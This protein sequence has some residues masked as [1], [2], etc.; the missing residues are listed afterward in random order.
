LF[1]RSQKATVILVLLAVISML[2]FVSLLGSHTA[3]LD[4]FQIEFSLLI[5]DHGYTQL[6]V[7]PLGIV[8]AQTHFS[9]LMLRARLL[10]VDLAQLRLLLE[11]VEDPAYLDDLRSKTRREINIFLVRLLFLAFLGGATGPLIFG[12]RNR[13]KILLAGLIGMIILGSL[14]ALSY[15]TFEP[16]AFMNPEFEGILKAAPWIFGL[17]EESLLR[18]RS[19]GEQLELIAA[20]M[21][22]LFEQIEQLEPLGTVEG[23]LKVVHVSDLHNN[24]AGM[25]FLAQVVETFAIDLVIDTGDITDFGTDIEAGLASPIE[26]FGIPYIFVPGNHDSP[27]VIARLQEIDNVIVLEEKQIEVLGLRVAGIA[28]PSAKDMGMVV[29]ADAIL[30]EYAARLHRVLDEAERLPHVVAVHHPRIAES[31]L[32][33]VQVV[34]TGHTH[35]FS[36]KERGDSVMI[37]AGTTG[38][39]GIRGLQVREETPYSLVLLHFGRQTGGE[40]FLRAADVIRVF[41][42]RSGFSLE[43]HMFGLAGAETEELQE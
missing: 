31:F 6:E 3:V 14:L 2:A 25:D 5:F 41:K 40:L 18:V 36:I 37:N 30:K 13:K 9:P 24:P 26:H 7:P 1:L 28:D 33:R 8:R 21:S 38:A 20:N 15:A 35:Q 4:A 43:R 11:K 29:A 27:N 34:L 39:S 16:M 23:D 17:L 12:E 32:D 19:L 10:N 22:V 42:L